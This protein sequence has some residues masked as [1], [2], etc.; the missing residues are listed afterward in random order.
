CGGSSGG[1]AAIV[2]T[3]GSALGLGCDLGGS[4]RI[5][6]RYCGLAGLLPTSGRLPNLGVRQHF[7]LLTEMQSS[8]GP[9]ARRVEDL[10]LAMRV[11]TGWSAGD[12]LCETDPEPWPDYRRLAGKRL[13]IGLWSDDGNLPP[14]AAISRALNEAA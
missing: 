13:R 5:P 2:A 3:G 14:S 9:C 7:S 1:E 12:C 6:A 11:M 8:A 4:I 10:H